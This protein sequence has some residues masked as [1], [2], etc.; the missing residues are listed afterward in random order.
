MV[1]HSITLFESLINSLI[2]VS[3]NFLYYT[4]ITSKAQY[5]YV[6]Q[7]STSHGKFIAPYL[8]LYKNH[9]RHL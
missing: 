7:N 3:I 4:N 1:P 6:K 2:E 9:R 5:L 8:P